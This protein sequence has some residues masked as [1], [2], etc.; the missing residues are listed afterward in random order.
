MFEAPLEIWDMLLRLLAAC[1]C[2]MAIGWERE[3]KNKPAGLRT[4]T[5]VALGSAGFTLVAWNMCAQLAGT[6][7][8]LRP[9]PLR[10]VDGIIGGIGFLGAGAIMQSQGSIKGITTAAAIWVVGALGI[11]CGLGFY[12]IAL[13]VSVFSIA[14]LY[15]LGHLEDEVLPEGEDPEEKKAARKPKD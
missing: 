13:L 9:D 15:A 1:A 12:M 7:S 4:N 6:D 10:L 5:M 2:G 3:S 11:A 8:S 14:V